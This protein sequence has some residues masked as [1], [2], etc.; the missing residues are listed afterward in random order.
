MLVVVRHGRT[1]A[2][3]SGLLL[4]RADPDLDETGR[5]QA[6]AL[7]AAVG[8]A[9]GGRASGGRA[10][11]VVS[12]PLR[13]TRQ[14]AEAFGGDV[15]VDDR[16]VE[17]D[18]GEWDGRPVN[19]VGPEEWA[20]WRADVDF[21]PPGGESLRALGVRVR[22]GLE[23]WAEE[24]VDTDVVIVTHVS[25]VKAAVAWALD[26]GDDLAWRL[27]VAPASV[28]RIGVGARR[29]LVEFNGVAHLA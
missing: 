1:E 2:N 3:A 12:S 25:P 21:A 24:A 5:E 20:R 4:G 26:A 28:T 17:L 27:F 10:P 7:A 29:V 15:V 8:G 9:A 14:T 11:V 19:G 22:A 18:Y 16:F 23:A 13:R 6:R